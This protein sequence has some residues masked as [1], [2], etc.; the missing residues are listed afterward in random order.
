MSFRISCSEDEILVGIDFLE[1]LSRALVKDTF[2]NQ[3][4][5]FVKIIGL[6]AVSEGAHV[7]LAELS[8]DSLSGRIF[9]FS[10]ETIGDN[11]Y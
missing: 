1:S 6:H 3:A 11:K 8:E 5:V 4:I 7:F 10:W 9:I 2:L